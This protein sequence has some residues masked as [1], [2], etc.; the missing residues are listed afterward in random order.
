M[1]QSAVTFY[2]YVESY[3]PYSQT[4]MNET[5]PVSPVEADGTKLRHIYQTDDGDANLASVSL[6]A[7]YR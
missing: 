1:L 3:K 4:L 2:L 5:R 7:F 6:S